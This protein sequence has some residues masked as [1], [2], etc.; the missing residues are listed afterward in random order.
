M[1]QTKVVKKIKTY[2]FCSITSFQKLRRLWDKV[3]KYCTAGQAIDEDMEQAHY[4]LD[5]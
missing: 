5:T 3:E 4:M 1:F 2:V